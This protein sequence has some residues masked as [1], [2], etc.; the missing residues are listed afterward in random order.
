M[1]RGRS[2]ISPAHNTSA[3]ARLR[4]MHGE[5]LYMYKQV[6]MYMYVCT[7]RYYY[8]MHKP[9]MNLCI[10]VLFQ[11]QISCAG[12]YIYTYYVYVCTYMYVHLYTCMSH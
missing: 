12:K 11:N 2:Y 9:Q 1:C 6:C 7:C 3:S 10:P 8:V 4:W 5:I